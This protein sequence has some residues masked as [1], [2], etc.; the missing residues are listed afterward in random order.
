MEVNQHFFKVTI[1]RLNSDWNLFHHLFLWLIGFV[2]TT[3]CLLTI[4]Q[5]WN[6]SNSLPACDEAAS[7]QLDHISLQHRVARR[8]TTPS[9]TWSHP[10]V[11]SKCHQRRELPVN[12]K[13]E[14]IYIYI[15]IFFNKQKKIEKTTGGFVWSIVLFLSN[16][17][18]CTVY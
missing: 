17:S 10:L 12:K 2:A 16:I 14:Y 1:F 11:L 13:S 5:G 6:P 15:H 18:L 7:V 8:W 9:T 3:S 4:F